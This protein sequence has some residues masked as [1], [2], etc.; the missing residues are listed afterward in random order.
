M[1]PRSVLIALMRFL[2]GGRAF[3]S[4]CRPTTQQRVYF[5][6]HASHMD[7]LLVWSA[8]P[9]MLRKT[10]HPVAAGDY[11]G[12]GRLRRYFA[13]EALGA[14]LIDRGAGPAALASVQDALDAGQSLILFPEG[15]RGTEILPGPFKSGLYHLAKSNPRVEFEPVY[16][17][18]LNRALTKC[19]WMPVPFSA[20]VI[21]GTPVTLT[22]DEPKAAYLE[23][24][25][26]AVVAMALK[27]H[28]QAS[29]ERSDA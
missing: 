7:S 5:C 1:N 3:W 2:V 29:G 20:W 15:T 6:N 21:F 24:A 17:D 11:W 19:V 8:L 12:H 28:P 16:L 23:R 9:A 25:R 22:Q 14:V 27:L 4:G 10:T 13:L 18:N 26:S